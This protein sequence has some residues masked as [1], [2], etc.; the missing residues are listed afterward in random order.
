MTLLGDFTSAGL[1]EKQ[2]FKMAAKTGEAR[3]HSVTTG[4][5]YIYRPKMISS[6]D[7]VGVLL[8]G[9]AYGVD[10]CGDMAYVACIN[11]VAMMHLATRKV[12]TKV[13]VPGTA[14]SLTASP[15]GK[16]VYVACQE[17]GLV[18]LRREADDSLAIAET[19]NVPALGVAM[20]AAKPVAVVACDSLGLCLFDTRTHSWSSMIALHHAL[21]QYKARSVAIKD[22]QYAIVACDAGFL[23][24]VDIV[25]PKH[26]RLVSIDRVF[27]GEARSISLDDD[28]TTAYVA[29]GNKGIYIVNIVD[30]EAVK[31]LGHVKSAYGA[32]FDVKVFGSLLLCA[33]QIGG[34]AVFTVTNEKPYLRLVG[35]NNRFEGICHGVAGFNVRSSYGSHSREAL[36]TC[37]SGGIQVIKLDRM[38]AWPQP[39]K[40]ALG[41]ACSIM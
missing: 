37:Q 40:P 9:L 26:P 13:S 4:P 1:M 3:R 18:V 22:D 2:S 10:T 6:P 35:Q 23:A 41:E 30:V 27:T 16:A 12:L 11:Y 24:V 36:V 39:L 32:V 5:E 15:S 20:C 14:L 17:G 25:D 21:G 33:C 7:S 31:S 28:N 29:C 34:L 19:H 38:E 8:G